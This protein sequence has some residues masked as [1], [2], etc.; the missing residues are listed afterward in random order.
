MSYSN[1]SLVT[2]K[3][4]STKH[5]GERTHKIDTITIHCFVGQV[6]AKRGCDF[7]ATTDRDCS[8][9][10]VVGTDGSIGLCV[11]EKNRSWCS[12]NEANDQRAIT[13][14]VA[15]DTVA[16]YAV[17]DKAYNA[18]IELLADVCKRNGIKKLLWQA[19][20]VYIGVVDKQNMTVHKWFAKKDCPGEYLY[21]RHGDIASKTNKLLENNRTN[22]ILYKV[23][24]GAY[25][26][27]SNAQKM[28]QRLKAD[29]YNPIIKQETK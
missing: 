8:C 5:S 13:I 12:S 19:N 14:E 7:F 27:Y 23:Q 21:S 26:N 20:P 3:R 25:S 2:Y 28:V 29:G 16:P 6:T 18:L 22:S 9:N 24:V 10:Y 4:L 1:S 15:S 11:E 17:T